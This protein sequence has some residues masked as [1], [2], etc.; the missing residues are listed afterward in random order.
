M[1]DL[2]DSLQ[3]PCGL[4]LR[5]HS[6]FNFQAQDYTNMSSP[7]VDLPFIC[8]RRADGAWDKQPYS[9][10]LCRF[11]VRNVSPSII[12]VGRASFGAML[13]GTSISP[14]PAPAPASSSSLS[15]PGVVPSLRA[16]ILVA[17]MP[18]STPFL[19]GNLFTQS[20]RFVT[21]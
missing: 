1:I 5:R 7:G 15:P 20:T 16:T 6:A 21:V 11:D 13:V 19:S 12:D 9:A 17:G 10:S 18:P 2:A 4:R 14:C 8:A 3:P